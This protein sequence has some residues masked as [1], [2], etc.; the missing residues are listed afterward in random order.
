M[1]VIGVLTADISGSE[2]LGNYGTVLVTELLLY[3]T[4]GTNTSCSGLLWWLSVC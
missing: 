4:V 3:R 1:V 2:L